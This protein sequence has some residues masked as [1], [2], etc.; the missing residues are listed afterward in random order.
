MSSSCLLGAQIS[1]MYEFAPSGIKN[2]HTR[3]VRP[4]ARAWGG[5]KNLYSTES[6][7]KVGREKK[8]ILKRGDVLN[9]LRMKCTACASGEKNYGAFV[10]SV[11]GSRVGRGFPLSDDAGSC[12]ACKNYRVFRGVTLSAG[13]VR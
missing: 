1:G 2:A 8:K 7:A 3:V 9:T 6:G 12:F 13:A 5:N 10:T 4:S 11:G